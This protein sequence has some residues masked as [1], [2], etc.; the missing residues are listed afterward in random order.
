[1]SYIVID[2][3]TASACDL[4]KAGAARYAEDVTTEVLCLGYSLNGGEEVVLRGIDQ[5]AFNWEGMTA[6]AILANDPTCIFVAH[7]CTFEKAIWRNIMVKLLGWPDVPN[8]RWH[9]SLAVCAMKSIPMKLEKAAQAMRLH[10]ATGANHRSVVTLPSKFRKDGSSTITP[11]VL[12][13]VYRENILDVKTETELNLRIGGFQPGERNVWLLDQ[14]INERGVR[15]DLEFVDACQRIIDGATEPALAKF[16][17]ITGGINPGQ[18]AAVVSWVNA[19]GVALPNLQKETIT[20]LLGL[21]DEE[22]ED[23]DDYTETE[24]PLLPLPDAVREALTIRR[25]VGS[26][27]IKKLAAISTSACGD[28]RVRGVVQYHGAGPGRWVGRLFQPQNFP[29]GTLKLDGD[30]AD[31]QSVYDT[32][33]TGDWK[34]AEAIFGD[35][36]ET[37]VSGLRHSIVSSPGRVLCVGDFATVEARIVLALAGAENAIRIITDKNRDVYAEM[38]ALI[39]NLKAP[40]GKDAVK[41]WKLAHLAE[42]QTGKN[43]VLGCGFQMGDK[44]Y[45]KRYC[46]EQPPEFAKSCIS[47]YREDFAPEVPGLWRGLE[48]A[49][50]EAVWNRRTTEAY[51]FEFKWEDIWLTMRLPSGR[52]LYYPYPEAIKKAMPWDETDVRRAWTCKASKGGRF[53]TRDMYGG[54]T[55]QNAVEGVARDLMVA[56]M[57]KC[58]KENLPVV[59]TVHDEIVTEPLDSAGVSELLKQIMCDREPWAIER[60]IPVDADCWAGERYRK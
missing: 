55:T 12:A 43:T 41:A 45:H 28:S 23:D 57:F 13:D 21:H 37:V 10:N 47:A 14:R 30:S 42:R 32:L 7:N 19:Q 50:I 54:K 20:K 44:T 34:L 16:R 15:V 18:T 2:F 35:A 11:E 3:E 9:D 46:P 58:E 8:P 1:M 52:K 40:F 59:L 60:N 31:V 51:G 4:T 24:T 49:A 26:A 27:S 39:F 5:L 6:L 29:R 36:Y 56:A 38:A 22:D 17:G 33:I 25:K 53:I 48:T